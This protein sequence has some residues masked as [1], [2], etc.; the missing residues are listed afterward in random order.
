MFDI[1]FAELMMIAVVA[2]LVIG[3]DKL[4]KVARTLGAYSGRLQR[5]ISQ[6]K[7]E[8]N[9]EVRFEELQSLQQEIEQGV[10]K[11]TS[12]IMD[13]VSDTQEALASTG[14]EAKPKR[15]AAVTRNPTKKPS[16]KKATIK[17]T[18]V[19]KLPVKKKAARKPAVKKAPVKR[20]K[21]SS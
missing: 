12:S 2:L 17:K 4:P 10:N 9:R 16:A 1:S 18:P 11:A 8:V 19:K 6:V 3:P 21:V 15:K 7:E 5:Y 13:G 20:A 14:S